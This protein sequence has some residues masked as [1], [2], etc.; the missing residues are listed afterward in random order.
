VHGNIDEFQAALEASPYSG[1]FYTFDQGYEA[2]L[3][4]L[5]VTVRSMGRL[6]IL[7]ACS[8]CFFQIFY[9][10][11]YQGSEKKTVG[12]MRSLGASRGRCGAYLW[13]SGFIVALGGI[14]LG[15]AAG[16]RITEQIRAGILEDALGGLDPDL[17]QEAL[18]SAQE[19]I[20]GL[21]SG[22]SVTGKQMLIIAGAELL[23]AAVLLLLH[24][25]VLIRR[26]PRRLMEG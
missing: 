19:E 9:L 13:G 10:L 11:M 12:T 7:S 21:I 1:E 18:L 3:K 4:N 22:S 23:I 26:S 17:P 2:V 15:S 16:R 24:T 5:N 6:L 8:W 25:G 14:L 20:R